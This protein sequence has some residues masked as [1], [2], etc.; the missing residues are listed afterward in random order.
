LLSV[1]EPPARILGN[2]WLCRISDRLYLEDPSTSGQID[3]L[4]CPSEGKWF[5]KVAGSGGG[6]GM[7]LDFRTDLIDRMAFRP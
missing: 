6:G 7:A 1:D 2:R 5:D 4:V 3:G